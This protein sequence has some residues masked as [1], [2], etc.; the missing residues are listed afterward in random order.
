M[1]IRFI[2]TRFVGF[3]SPAYSEPIKFIIVIGCHAIYFYAEQYKSR[4]A[5]IVLNI[6]WERLYI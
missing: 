2:A 1:G 4:L 3:F 5:S 6:A